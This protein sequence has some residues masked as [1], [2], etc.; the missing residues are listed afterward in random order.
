M[1]S[2]T[3]LLSL[4]VV[5]VWL[6]IL[7]LWWQAYRQRECWQQQAQRY[8]QF[9]APAQQET[10]TL[11]EWY[12]TMATVLGG[13]RVQFWQ[14]AVPA[15]VV[16]ITLLLTVNGMTWFV[17][18]SLSLSVTAL[19][20]WVVYHQLQQQALDAFRDQLPEVIDGMIRAVRVGA[21]MA[22]TFAV[23]ADQ[24]GEAEDQRAVVSRLFGQ[25]HDEL[26]VGQP[27]TDVLAK[28]SARMPVA[29]FRFLTV[30]LSL[31]QETGGRLSEVLNQLGDTLRGRKEL[32]ASVA[33]IT[34]ESRSSA[35]VLAALP[36]LIVL[37]LFSAGREHFDYL[38]MTVQGQMVVGYVIGSILFGLM[39]IRRLTQ[40]KA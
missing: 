40:I 7:G 39:L 2:I 26:R 29:E 19:G 33:S 4:L 14:R 6:M 27:L 15:A 36:V 37:V 30:V 34:S 24:Y 10:R 17:A 22:D 1:L 35:K 16:A 13:K 23:I 25:M 3:V 12:L 8:S 31:Q 5:S 20:V 9:R 28:A 32:Q 11:P 21:P 38:M 18:L